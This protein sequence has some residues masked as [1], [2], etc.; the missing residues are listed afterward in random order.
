MNK[1]G[2]KK[3]FD[4]IVYALELHNLNPEEI[5]FSQY[6][7]IFKI[8]RK[9]EDFYYEMLDQ[10]HNDDLDTFQSAGCLMAAVNKSE[11][12]EE[13]GFNATFA[14]DI[15]CKMCENPVGMAEIDFNE[16]FAKKAKYFNK[17]REVIVESLVTDDLTTP[18]ACSLSLKSL[19]DEALKKHDMLGK[20]KQ[21][22][23][24]NIINSL[25]KES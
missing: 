20:R 1:I 22:T 4:L 13:N 21:F 14:L 9:Y 12:F 8:H 3:V 2:Q 25:K 16:I 17:I 23:I 10:T 19:Y 15:A 11:F 18:L 6:D 7:K 24:K 5:S